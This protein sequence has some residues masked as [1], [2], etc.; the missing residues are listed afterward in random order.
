MGVSQLVR[1]LTLATLCAA[2]G[3]QQSQTCSTPLIADGTPLSG[4]IARGVQDCY[5]LASRAGVTYDIVVTL[6]TLSDSVLTLVRPPPSPS[7]PFSR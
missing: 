1:T 3:G 5:V 2:S 4:D 6:G 7:L